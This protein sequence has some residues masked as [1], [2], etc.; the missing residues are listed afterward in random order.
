MLGILTGVGAFT[1]GYGQ[2]W[3][4]LS[5][6]PATCANCHGPGGHSVGGMRP[7]AGRSRTD[8]V[9]ALREFREGRRPATIM[10]QLARGFTE[11]QIEAVSAYLSAQ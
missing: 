8:L 6:N 11:E 2:G 7:I 9:R 1:F 3:S 4:Y 10:Q 5:N